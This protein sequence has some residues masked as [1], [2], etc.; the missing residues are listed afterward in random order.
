M[1]VCLVTSPRFSCKPVRKALPPPGL[2]SLGAVARQ[3]G[4]AVFGV[5]GLLIGDPKTIAQRVAAC[6]P[7]VVGTNTSTID[8]LAGIRTI[9]QIRRAVPKAFIVVGG[10]HFAHSADDA[11]QSIPQIDAVAVGEGEQTFLELLE[12]L[13]ARDALGQIDG[14]VYRDKDGQIIRNAPRQVMRD[15]NGLPM[16]AWDLFEIGEYRFSSHGVGKLGEI[17]H[18][19]RTISCIMTTRGCP[20]SCVFCANSL[21]KRMR[22]LDPVLAV[23]QIEWQHKEFGVTAL[24]V[25]DDDFLTSKR[26]AGAFCEELLRRKQR[27]T[28]WCGARPVRLDRELLKLM[29]RSGCVCISFGVESGADSVLKTI[30]KNFTRDQVYEAMEIAGKI[31]FEKVDIFL[32]LGLPGE[33]IDT[34]DET[35]AFANSLKG[36][37]GDAWQ[38]E[39][40]IG[41][42]P[43]IY[44]GTE[45]EQMGYCHGCLPEDF[46]WNKPYLEP[47]RHLPLVNHRYNSV[48]HFQN[49][50]L[51]LSELCAHVKKHHW[52]ELSSGRKRRYRA[53]PLRKL[54]VALHLG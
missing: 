47:D 13:P 54:K 39:S 21:S 28:W 8:R 36:P 6:E 12:H 29:R 53:A 22:F 10:S 25:Y 33:T 31:G 32:I 40:L 11:L 5:D 20:Q 44:P 51:G 30:R 15:I 27:F 50:H 3:A 16:P 7:D 42:L 26:H 23:D 9:R 45:M 49:R 34:I 38:R 35:V 37:L 4:H 1:N 18:N 41:Q 2:A 46:S 17:E 43:L 14:L 52:S 48:P 19:R 24:N